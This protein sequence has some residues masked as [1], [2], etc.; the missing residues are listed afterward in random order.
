MNFRNMSYEQMEEI[1]ASGYRVGIYLRLSKDDDIR[2]RESSS[3]SHQREMLTR[4]CEKRGW[5]IEKEYVDDGYSGLSMKRPAIQKLLKDV[6]DKKINL[7]ITKDYSRLGRDRLET[8]RLRE[9]FF[10]RNGCRYIAVNDNIDTMYD[11]DYAPFKAIINEQYSKDISKKVHSAYLSQAEKGRFTGSLPPFGYKKDPNDP[12]HLVIDEETA[13]Y[14]RMIFEMARDGHGPAYIKRRL[15]EKE[16]P[17]PTWW[18]R[19]RGLR[20]HYT[21]YELQDP[22]KGKYIWDETVLTDMLISPVYYGAVAGQKKNYKFKLGI[23]SEKDPDEWIIVENMHEPIVDEQMF[24]VVQEKIKSRK[25]CRRGDG[26]TSLF[27]GLIKCGECGK[28]L[29][30]RKTNAKHPIDIYA[31]KTYNHMGKTHCTQHRIEFDELYEI[32]LNEIKEIAKRTLDD[33]IVEDIEKQCTADKNSEHAA[34]QR[35]VMKA[36]YRLDNIERIISKLYDDLIAERISER[37]FDAVMKRTNQEQE[38][39]NRL[40]EEYE[41]ILSNDNVYD[42]NYDRWV[43]LISEYSDIQELDSEMLNQIVKKIVVHE[44]IEDDGKRIISVE[45]HYNFKPVNEPHIHY[46]NEK[47]GA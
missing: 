18:N 4:Y 37:N 41:T 14:V 20:N 2:E 7:V 6:E 23:L 44:N 32:V 36:R 9:E 45:I 28:A 40:I 25:C 27:A 47:T 39:L 1:L 31:C 12:S 42:S 43:E 13:P 17:C 29:T 3:I 26:T 33:D 16:I 22:E 21:K 46:L 24:Y 34:M 30:I 8:E 38:E 19:E 35:Q 10:P 5:S 15:E 11:D